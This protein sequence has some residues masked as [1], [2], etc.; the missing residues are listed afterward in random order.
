MTFHAVCTKPS[1]PSATLAAA[2]LLAACLLSLFQ[3]L[4]SHA[5][6]LGVIT[7]IDRK[8]N[9]LAIDGQTYRVDSFSEVRQ[10]GG[11]GT[12][13]VAAWYSLNV[14]DYVVFDARDGR[15]KSLRRESADSLDPPRGR[16]IDPGAT[17]LEER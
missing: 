15:I 17:V 16:P 13:E 1:R 7:A 11:D 10:T 14:G 8:A 5:A 3:P 2:A 4:A 12:E 9:E 6:T